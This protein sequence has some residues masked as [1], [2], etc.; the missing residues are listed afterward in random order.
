MNSQL[1]LNLLQNSWSAVV[2]LGNG[3]QISIWYT[4]WPM[5]KRSVKNVV[6]VASDYPKHNLIK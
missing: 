4:A 3:Q 1:N 5:S 6:S 2:E